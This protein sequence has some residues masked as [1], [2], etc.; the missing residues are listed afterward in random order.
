MFGVQIHHINPGRDPGRNADKLTWKPLP[1][2]MQHL[3]I[4]RGIAEAV[5]CCWP[6]VFS[7]R[8]AWCRLGR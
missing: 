7:A 3:W 6:L 5:W 2:L 4:A 1:E 8:E